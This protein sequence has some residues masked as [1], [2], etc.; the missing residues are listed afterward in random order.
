MGTRGSP[1]PAALETWLQCAQLGQCAKPFPSVWMIGLNTRVP[2][3]DLFV[4]SAGNW[5]ALPF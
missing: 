4:F 5:A 1:S 3:V 2:E